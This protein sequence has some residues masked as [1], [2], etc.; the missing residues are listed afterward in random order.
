MWFLVA[1]LDARTPLLLAESISN[2]LFKRSLSESS[3]Q[4]EQVTG[5]T[6]G[7]TNGA[8]KKDKSTP[9]KASGEKVEPSPGKV[10][11]QPKAKSGQAPPVNADI[12]DRVWLACDYSKAELG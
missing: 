1:N 11:E 12:S 9:Q 3:M 5:S 6:C 10:V 2:F 8:K 7:K 4:G